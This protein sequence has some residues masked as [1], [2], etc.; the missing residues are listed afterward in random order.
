MK[1][2]CQKLFYFNSNKIMLRRAAGRA[3]E[4][5]REFCRM[6]GIILKC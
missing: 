6:W 1:Q 5:F 3:E 2:P 4:R